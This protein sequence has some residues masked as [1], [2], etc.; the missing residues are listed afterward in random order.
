MSGMP[1]GD[2]DT[3][4]DALVG[5]SP[6]SWRW[7]AV[8]AV[9]VAVALA[10]AGPL[11]SGRRSELAGAASA[12]QHLR[13]SWL[14]LAVGAEVG[15]LA[16]YVALQHRLL[17]SSGVPISLTPLTGITLAGNAIQNSLPGGAA[18]SGLF[19]F[20]QLRRRGADTVRA[21]WTLV[22]V[23]LVSDAG[24]A[25][26]FLVGLVAAH[27]QTSA[28]DVAV[29]VFVTASLV[30]LVGLVIRRSVRKGRGPD[31][32]IWLVQRSQWVV[33]RPRGD[34]PAMVE[35]AFDRLRAV[36]PSRSDWAEAFGCAV[37]NWTFDCGCL[38]AAFA[39]VHASVPWRGLLL[40]YGTG[41]LAANL[42]ITP[43]GLGVVEGSLSIALV[44]YGGVRDSTVA[45]VLLYRI[46]SFWSLLPLGWGSWVL[47]QV[48]NHRRAG[49]VVPGAQ[50]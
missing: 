27:G 13:V 36:H 2:Q 48:S 9:P 49:A 19:A 20:R 39:A 12:L 16:S 33:R 3:L 50:P 37:A 5:R 30:V 45:A 47:L 10:V 31:I 41:Q 28:T 35:Q 21:G 34:A 7:W 4:S 22:A 24:L 46:I 42:P 29:A 14:L 23:A 40:A 25:T 43:G 44:Y 15:S 6:R 26:L 11:L 18:W 38:A 1:T 17:A 32:C 8:R